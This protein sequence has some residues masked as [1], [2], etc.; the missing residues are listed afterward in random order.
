MSIVSKKRPRE[1]QRISPFSRKPEPMEDT[2]ATGSEI[3]PDVTRGGRKFA[4]DPGKSGIERMLRQPAG[5]VRIVMK[6]VDFRGD[7]CRAERVEE[8]EPDRGLE[9]RVTDIALSFFE[10][11]RIDSWSI[12]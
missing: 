10:Y 11:A 6:L 3:G 12:G 4:N 2:L 9:P 5:T 8:G 7:T 1:R